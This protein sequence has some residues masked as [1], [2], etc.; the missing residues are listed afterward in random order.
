MVQVIEQVG[1]REVQEWIYGVLLGLAAID[2]MDTS[3]IQLLDW[4][5][6]T[7]SLDAM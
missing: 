5:R 4:V 6:E 7:W 3:E 2:G 1:R